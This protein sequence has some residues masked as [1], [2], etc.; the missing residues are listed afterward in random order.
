MRVAIFTDNDF[1]KVNGVT[2][3]LRAVLAHAPSDID[4]RVYT[5][6]DRDQDDPQ[7]FSRRSLG[8]PIPLYGEMRVYVP[9]L[10]PFRA[11]VA[12]SDARVVHLTT[13]GPVGLAAMRIA[14]QLNLPM[15]GSFHT[16]LAAYARLLSGSDRLGGVMRTFLRWPYGRCQRVLAPS[17]A[18]RLMLAGAED[19]VVDRR[20]IDI[21]RR[22][23]DSVRFT[24][25]RRDQAIRDAWGV[26]LER[27]AILY[28]GRVSREKRLQLLPALSDALSRHGFAHRFII[29]G[30]GPMDEELRA[31]LPDAVFTGVLHGDDL[32]AAYASADVFVFPSQTDTAGNV[33]LEAQASGL[34]VLV[35]GIG[36]PR[37][38]VIDG[39][40]GHVVS[41]ETPDAWLFHLAPLLRSGGSRLAMGAAARRYAELCSW[42]NA[43]APL[44]EAYRELAGEPRPADDL[45][46]LRTQRAAYEAG[47]QH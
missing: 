3:T 22:G 12:A 27:P 38:N 7:Y 34:P 21:W 18:T 36:G 32:A 30:R 24:P 42:P 35:S 6:A 40:T 16:D 11:A 15:V 47:R 44:Y 19:G 8:M 4:L 23:V 26:S 46:S 28:V 31:R 29:V 2:T 25:D 17:D 1:A 10:A 9:R 33:V 41:G 20:R 39:Q 37:E 43:L 5:A 45:L 13:P 14:R